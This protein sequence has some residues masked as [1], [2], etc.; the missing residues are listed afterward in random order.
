MYIVLFSENDKCWKLADF[1]TASQATSKRLNT[2][3]DARGTQGYR[4]PEILVQSNARY[5]K[6]SDIFALGG[7]IYEIVTGAKLFFE[8]AAILNYMSRGRLPES[9]WWP[10]SPAGNP[11]RLFCLEKLVASMLEL[12]SVNRPNAR[13]VLQKLALIR[14]G[15]FGGT[16][17]FLFGDNSAPIQVRHV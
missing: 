8:D 15:E 14:G 5:N 3:R 13:E 12:D 10:S 9:T 6:K 16:P 2:T 17:E 7:I 11:D 1:G 4:A